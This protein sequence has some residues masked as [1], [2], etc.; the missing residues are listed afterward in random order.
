[1]SHEKETKIK[2]DTLQ[3]SFYLSANDL[4][5]PL[6]PV[7]KVVITKSD[8]QLQLSSKRS[9][10]TQNSIKSTISKVK[11]R[12]SEEREVIKKL[13]ELYYKSID[14]ANK[15]VTNA[16]KI[17]KII[18]KIINNLEKQKKPSYPSYIA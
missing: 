3:T 5:P 4:P 8:Q 10:K 9:L 17:Q 2:Q 7:K 1:M 13:T 16:E 14:K 18:Q 6:E 12:K 15:H 11:S